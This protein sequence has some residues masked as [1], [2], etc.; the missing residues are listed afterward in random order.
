[1][2]RKLIVLAGMLIATALVSF[3]TKP[4]EAGW[5][6]GRPYYHYGWRPAWRRP[7]YGGYYGGYYGVPAGGVYYY[8]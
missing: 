6:N 3:E 4:L 8:Y 5:R 7:F 1:M 2:T